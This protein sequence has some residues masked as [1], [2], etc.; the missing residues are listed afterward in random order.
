M[1]KKDLIL[2]SPTFNS[3]MFL[4]GMTRNGPLFSSSLCSYPL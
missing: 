4:L 1:D 2:K 3:E